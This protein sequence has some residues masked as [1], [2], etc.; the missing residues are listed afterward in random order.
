MGLSEGQL[1]IWRTSPTSVGLHCFLHRPRVVF[2]ARVNMGSAPTRVT[3]ILYDTVTAGAYTDIREDMTLLLGSSPGEDDYGRAR[4]RR[5]TP[6]GEIATS[7]HILI[8]ATSRGTLDGELNVVNDAYI[9]VI[10]LHQIWAVPPY[11]D[12]F[13]GV[14]F[15]DTNRLL[16]A[17]LQQRPK[18]NAGADLLV[19]LPQV[20]DTYEYAYGEL[21]SYGMHPDAGELTYLWEFPDGQTATDA[22]G[23]VTLEADTVGY[24]YLTVTDE[25]GNSSQSKCL[26][27]VVNENH[28]DLIRQFQITQ[29]SHRREGQQLQLRINQPI[30]YQTY[31][32]G[33]EVLIAQR[34]RYGSTVTSLSST[35]VFA[36]W[37]GQES[38]TG[39]AS[40]RGFLT[41]TTIQCLDTAG[42]AAML[43]GFPLL[44]ERES[45]PADSSQM[46]GA[47]IDRYVFHILDEHSTIT[48]R[49]DFTPSGTWE[50][51]AFSTLGSDGASLYDQA[52]Q[53]TQAIAHKLTCDRRGRLWMKPDP[54]LQ[55]EGDRTDVVIVPIEEQ[56]WSSYQMTYTR[57]PRVHWNWGEAIVASTEDAADVEEIET[58]FC[59]APGA[60]PGQG[61]SSQ[62]SGEQL[63]KAT[64]SQVE[65]NYREGQRYAARLNALWGNVE[66]LLSRMGDAGIDPALMQWVQ[67]QITT[68]TAGVRARITKLPTNFLPVEV[69][70]EYDHRAGTR[71]TRVVLE[72]EVNGFPAE[73][74][75]PPDD[76]GFEIPTVPPYTPPV[77][78]PPPTPEVNPIPPYDGTNIVPTKGIVF[79]AAGAHCSIFTSFNPA[80]SSL[81]YTD[82][83]TGL[84][85][86][87]NI[88]AA[89][90][91]FNWNRYYALQSDGVYV[92]QSPFGLGTWS[93]VKDNAA[94][95]GDAGRIGKNIFTSINRAG[96]FGI[97]S[98]NMYV[99]TTD[100]FATVNRVAITGVE[101][102]QTTLATHTA[103]VAISHFNNPTG[104][105]RLYAL[106][107]LASG[108]WRVYRSD[109][110]GASWSI[111]TN[112]TPLSWSNV[113]L[114][115]PYKRPGGSTDNTNDSSQVVFIQ[116]GDGHTVNSGIIRESI[117]AGASFAT[118]YNPTGGGLYVPCG[119]TTGWALRTFTYD[120]DILLSATL[121][122]G[123]GGVA[124]GFRFATN[125]GAT[126]VY[127]SS[128]VTVFGS[129]T[130]HVNGYPVHNQAA[131]I[132]AHGGTDNAIR[133]TLDAGTT[134][135]TVDTPANFSGN[136]NASYVEWNIADLVS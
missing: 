54:L 111:V 22:S 91:A 26:I 82:V 135:T 46:Q 94:L 10:D 39:Q 127:N 75:I 20:G 11:I 98:G 61:V 89:G 73:T 53:R 78:V 44:V 67:F 23:T 25:R 42:R 95:F 49:A 126:T 56:D 27:A 4:V 77:Y 100:Y 9:T 124:G 45:A 3:H 120:S 99:Y 107:H 65:L 113:T 69:R 133:F 117:D 36:G 37:I 64:G 81:N 83:S 87:Y 58:V 21:P 6:N 62:T 2:A 66:V 34:E 116:G 32:D 90:D 35:M 74:Y 115:V 128:V 5:E 57:A 71:K 119:S 114:D 70:Y 104:T 47:N 63:V 102:Y 40:P 8:Q 51:Y 55:R 101:S 14:V 92:N 88:W 123:A 15:K 48:R 24:V 59:V 109:D 17:E 43:P 41:Q 105:G 136:R 106:V 96:Y 112:S 125:E 29:H 97:V 86:G 80:A 33:T 122:A 132:W 118:K 108:N 52:D 131:L 72:K 134:L 30:P 68:D 7:S 16:I 121:A 12:S 79:D 13:T 60:T 18:A 31:P 130:T 38:V 129:Q 103:A 110:W 28:E 50:D 19:V 76:P 84:G 1:A 85:S 93:R